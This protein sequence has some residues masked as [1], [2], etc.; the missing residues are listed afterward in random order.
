MRNVWLSEYPTSPSLLDH[1]PQSVSDPQYPWIEQLAEAGAVLALQASYWSYIEK[2]PVHVVLS[3][4]ITAEATDILAWAYTD[5]LLPSEARGMT[6]PFSQ[7]E[8]HELSAIL[9]SLDGECAWPGLL[10]IVS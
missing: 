5:R 2:H 9:R 6:P 7:D 4:M 8:C 3:S 10:I 1:L